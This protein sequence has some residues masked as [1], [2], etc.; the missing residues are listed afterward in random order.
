MN[1]PLVSIII[2]CFNAERWLGETLESI[3]AQDYRPIEVI[4]SDG[5]SKDCTADIVGQF[6]DVVTHFRSSPDQ[7]PADALNQGLAL[8]TGSVIGYINAD[9]LLKKGAVRE[10]VEVLSKESGAALVFRDIE[11]IDA[12]GKRTVGYGGKSK[13]YCPGAYEQS[14]HRLGYM[15]VPQ[16]GSFW[17]RQCQELVGEFDPAIKTSFDGHWYAR[18]S[19][20][21]VRMIYRPKISASFRVHSAAISYGFK[22]KQQWQD[23]HRRVEEIWANAGK[24]KFTGFSKMAVK[25][26][27]M[28]MRGVRHAANAFNENG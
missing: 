21:G 4:I 22:E 20:A 15:I 16:Q 9:D 24:Q 26:K 27:R 1:G 2:P 3:R 11:F 8:A 13:I 18:A 28:L 14:A 7:G 25:G 6:P 17:N 5:G 23:G 10:A 19:V 12:D